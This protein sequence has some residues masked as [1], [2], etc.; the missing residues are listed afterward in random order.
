MKKKPLFITALVIVIS[1]IFLAMTP[2]KQKPEQKEEPCDESMEQCCQKKSKG[3]TDNMIMETL[4]GQFF[5]Y[6]GIR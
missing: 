2:H 1:G 5:T 6:S 4:S 3:G